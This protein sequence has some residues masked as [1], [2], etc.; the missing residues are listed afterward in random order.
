MDKRLTI[1]LPE[2]AQGL[3]VM[4]NG[5]FG[6][7]TREHLREEDEAKASVLLKDLTARVKV[8]SK[9]EEEQVRVAK[10]RTIYASPAPSPS[11]ST[12]PDWNSRK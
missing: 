6:H 9:E 3:Y 8:A 1:Y 12:L 4:S 10:E 2:L 5:M 7:K 11:S